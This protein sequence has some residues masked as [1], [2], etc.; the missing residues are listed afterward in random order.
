[1]NTSWRT[2]RAAARV[3]RVMFGEHNAPSVIIPRCALLFA[4]PVDHQQYDDSRRRHE[5]LGGPRDRIVDAPADIARDQSECDA[6]HESDRER[7]GKTAQA[8]LPAPE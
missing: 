4:D 3:T 2:A 7:L 5:H 6:D 1:M 8:D